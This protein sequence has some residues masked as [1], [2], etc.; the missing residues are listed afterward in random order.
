MQPGF[1][2]G[3]TIPLWSALA[4]IMPSLKDHVEA[5]KDNSIKWTNYEESEEDKQVYVKH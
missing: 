4:D 3:I 1:I 2:N 5:A